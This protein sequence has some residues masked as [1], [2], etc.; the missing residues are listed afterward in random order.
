MNLST[1]SQ[2]LPQLANSIDRRWE[3]WING[4]GR[5]DLADF[6]G[7]LVEKGVVPEDQVRSIISELDV[8]LTLSE[9][10]RLPEGPRYRSFGLLGRGAMGEV[11]LARDRALG[12]NVAV[13]ALDPQL[14]SEPALAARFHQEAQITAQLDHPCIVP[15]Y[16]I[17]SRPDGS[18]AYSMKLVKGMELA[19]GLKLAREALDAG[20]PEPEDL[21]LNG[22][23]VTFLSVCAA[24]SYAHDR[25]VLHRDLKPANIMLGPHHE[26]LVMDWGIAKVIGS[27]ED[28][29][30]ES[31]GARAHETQIGIVVGTPQY[32]SPEQASADGS[33][34][35]PKS[36][37]YALGLI[38]QEL[39]TLKRAVTAKNA[40]HAVMRAQAA[41]RD[42]MEHYKGHAVP[43][44]LV[45][46][47]NK[48][49][50][51]D[52]DDRYADVE[53][54]A[55]DVRHFLRD[56]PVIAAPDTFSQRM[57]RWVGRH[58]Q[59]AI[60]SSAFLA[61]MV[62]AVSM[63]G[64]LGSF[65][66]MQAAQVKALQREEDL[67]TAVMNVTEHA[68]RIDSEL[69]RYEALVTGIAFA[70]EEALIRDPDPATVVYRSETFNP[71]DLAFSEFYD[72]SISVVYPDVHITDGVDKDQAEREAHQLA[73]IGPAL[74]QALLMSKGPQ[75]AKRPLA[76]RR[77]LVAEGK[78]PAVW[79]YVATEG[80]VIAGMPGVTEFEEGYDPRGRPWYQ[81][82]KASS[83]PHWSALD[84]DE[85]GMG[86]L[87]TCTLSLHDEEGVVNGV[88]ALD[89]TF[90][91]VIE[92][93]LDI[94]EYPGAT[95]LLVNREGNVVASSEMRGNTRKLDDYS[96]KPFDEASILP[97]L[98]RP[99]GHLEVGSD[100]YLWRRLQ[101]VDDWAYVVKIPVDEAIGS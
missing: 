70:A 32:M 67:A 48:A 66:A 41:S 73:G 35:T 57:Q 24:M 49:C 69:A 20:K 38:L 77:R 45:A 4:G 17:E 36:D 85:G 72:D 90:G 9:A 8:A 15:V 37:Q 74:S 29:L 68:G 92:E 14:V 98:D 33:A 52:P 18:P 54:L 19:D 51:P 83:G 44:E 89:L 30:P 100:L 56:E 65:L 10:N 75:A 39:V 53:E 59:L 93:M 82:G 64:V 12:R 34:L 63:L 21:D 97:L 3:A 42:P 1:L 11:Y 27:S 25:G 71:P 78:T 99:A 80:G 94:E 81:Q 16:G 47:V 13:K 6:L 79:T 61:F 91:Y 55:D 40:M 26:V 31:A 84:L 86:L 60:A 23:L 28:I 88:A 58:R 46:V 50:A 22:R 62:F 7:H 76:A 96:P 2:R 87:L 43:R 5:P 101:T 95:A